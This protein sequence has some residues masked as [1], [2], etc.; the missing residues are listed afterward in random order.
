MRLRLFYSEKK[1]VLIRTPVWDE[2]LDRRSYPLLTH[3][4]S[5]LNEQNQN[6]SCYRYTMGQYSFLSKATQR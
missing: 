2:S 1:S 4:D 3:K 5:N 6:L